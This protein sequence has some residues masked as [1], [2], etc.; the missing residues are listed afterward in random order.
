VGGDKLNK[1]QWKLYLML[2]L[3]SKRLIYT[4]DVTI[5][6]IMGI[7]GRF[8]GSFLGGNKVR[9]LKVKT[10]PEFRDVLNSNRY[11]VAYFWGR[12]CPVCSAM[13]PVVKKL[14]E[15]Y[16][17]EVVFLDINAG[18]EIGNKFKVRTV[19]TFIIFE[20]GWMKKRRTGA[21]EYREF[22]KWVGSVIL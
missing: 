6:G 15:E 1:H 12:R 5:R 18:T 19:P 7:I 21:M 8:I 14:A 9:P 20:N 11:V 10:L 22:K 16:E 13:D 3:T 4:H 17:G 2:Y